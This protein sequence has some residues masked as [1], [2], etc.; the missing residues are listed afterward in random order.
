MIASLAAWAHAGLLRAVWPAHPL[1]F[2]T[3]ADYDVAKDDRKGYINNNGTAGALKR[4][5]DD[6]VDSWGVYGQTEWQLTEPS[7]L[8]AGLRFTKVNFKSEDHFLCFSAAGLCAGAT[9]SSNPHDR[10]NVSH[11][12]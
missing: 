4:D 6:T 3:C 9:G 5:E 8:S 12:A 11:S 1:T 10:G 7:F 2:T